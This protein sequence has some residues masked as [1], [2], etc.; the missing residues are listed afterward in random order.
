METGHES[1]LKTLQDIRS[2]MERSARFISLSGWSGIWAGAT[3]LAGSYIARKWLKQLPAA[4]Y[5]PYRTAP[6]TISDDVYHAMVLKFVLLAVTVFLVALAGAYYFTWR[7]TRLLGS[8]VWNNASRRLLVE[9][10]IPMITGGIFAL[11][12]LYA[13]HESFVAPT[14]LTFYGLAL[15]NGSKYTLSDVKYLGIG[16]VILGCISLFVPGFGLTFWALGFGVLHIIY[17]IVMWNKY[18]RHTSTEKA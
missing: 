15:I 1:S 7:K 4:Y 14:C 10:A 8:T 6:S 2:I 11:K 12:F 16:Q 3:A 18:D 13:H 9:I 5:S 17:G